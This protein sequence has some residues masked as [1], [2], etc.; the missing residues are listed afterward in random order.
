[1][2]A[3]DSSRGS[4]GIPTCVGTLEFEAETGPR[5][6]GTHRA[7]YEFGKAIEHHLFDS[8]VIVE[9]LQMAQ[10]SQCA[11]WMDVERRRRVG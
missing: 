11:A 3:A 2:A 7:V 1:M 8:L 9:V 5:P 4:G 6:I 10:P